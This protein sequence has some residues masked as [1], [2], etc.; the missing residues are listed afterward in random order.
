MRTLLRPGWVVCHVL[1]AA[2]AVVMVLLGNWQWSVGSETG[3]LRNYSYGVEWWVFAVMAVAGWV[4]ICRDELVPDPDAGVLFG[5]VEVVQPSDGTG[6]ALAD[7]WDDDP[8]V[9]AWNAQFARLHRQHA[10]KQA[11]REDRAGRPDRRLEE[12]R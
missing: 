1:V 4:K 3:S 6:L 8:E 5:S 7:Q 2:G 10:L 12:L 11:A 9:A